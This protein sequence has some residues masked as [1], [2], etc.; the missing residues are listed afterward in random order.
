MLAYSRAHSV[1]HGTHNYVQHTSTTYIQHT[2]IY[3]PYTQ[4]TQN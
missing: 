1:E 4:V 3:I 2:L